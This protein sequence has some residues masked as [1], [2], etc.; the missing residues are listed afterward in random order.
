VWIE[1][2]GNSISCLSRDA[3][4]YQV[5]DPVRFDFDARQ[6]SLFDVV[7]EQRL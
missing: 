4:E 6:I 2:A 7:D 3:R 5:G 1:A